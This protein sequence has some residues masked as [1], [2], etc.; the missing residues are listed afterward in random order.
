VPFGLDGIEIGII[1]VFLT[2]FAGI[3]TGFPVAFAIGGAGIISFAIIA[4]LDSA[5]S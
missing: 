1:I 2:L 5:G 3:M 4:A